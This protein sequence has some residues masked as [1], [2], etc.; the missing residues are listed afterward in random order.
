MRFFAHRGA[1]ADA[2]ENTLLA[3]E[4]AIRSGAKWI[5]I[6]IIAHQG[7][8]LVIHD[9]TLDR[10]TNGS[11]WVKDHTMAQLMRFDA[12]MGQRIPLLEEVLNLVAGRVSLNIELKSKGCAGLLAVLLTKPIFSALKPDLLVSSF[13]HNE[14]LLFQKS[15]PDVDLG[16][17]VYG[18]P[19]S[20]NAAIGV[21]KI[22]S[23]H[24]SAEFIDEPL[25]KEAKAKGLEVYIYTVN[26]ISHLNNLK[27]LPI[28]GVF[29]DH[30]QLWLGYYK[31]Q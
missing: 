1:M 23:L 29:T 9:L 16:L 17:L 15:C 5:E 8:L 31:I 22:R 28:D 13:D 11:G 4:L 27:H 26:E 7:N 18:V 2:P 24:I 19:L 30:S 6:D 20:L 21:L 3:I 14:L 12:G 10:T 25:I